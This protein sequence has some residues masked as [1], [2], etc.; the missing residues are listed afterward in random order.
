MESVTCVVMA[1]TGDTDDN[2]G[3]TTA[4]MTN[5]RPKTIDDYGNMPSTCHARTTLSIP[6]KVN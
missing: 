3:R 2:G 5:K 6:G 1:A 4:R